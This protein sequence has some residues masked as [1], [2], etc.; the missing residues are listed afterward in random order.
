MDIHLEKIKIM[1]KVLDVDEEWVIKGL[2]RLLNITEEVDDA[3]VE[4]YESKLKP[5]TKEELI[6][7]VLE[8]EEDFKNGR[9]MDIDEF[10]ES[11]KK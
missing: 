6:K 8:A 5:L 9:Y 10:F 1:R 7:H 11:I 2:K 3:F 4:E